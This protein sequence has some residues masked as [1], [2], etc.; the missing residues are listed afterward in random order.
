MNRQLKKLMEY[1]LGGSLAS[2]FEQKL[3]D[4]TGW[5]PD[6]CRAA[7]IEYKRF[8]YLAS[9]SSAPITPSTIVDEVWHLHLTFS[10]DYWGE[11]CQNLIEYP[12][13]HEP[14]E[15]TELE[16]ITAQYKQTLALYEKTFGEIP[17][18]AFWPTHQPERRSKWSQTLVILLGFFSTLLIGVTA[19]ASEVESTNHSSWWF[20]LAFGFIGFVVYKVVTSGPADKSKSKSRWFCCGGGC[21]SSC[22]GGGCGS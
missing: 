8:A 20:W 6:F 3:Q 15:P 17:A 22:G 10:R 9:I 5:T 2:L 19:T 1:K 16:T 14:S 18:T 13:H 12:L 21:G 4:Q 7:I 11:F